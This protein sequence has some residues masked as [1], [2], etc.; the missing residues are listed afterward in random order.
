MTPQP[1]PPTFLW[2]LWT[3]EA[4]TP[5]FLLVNES[6][7]LI[8]DSSN[9]AIEATLSGSVVG[10]IQETSPGAGAV[11]V[12]GWGSQVVTIEVGQSAMRI[13]GFEFTLATMA[14]WRQVCSEF[15][16]FTTSYGRPTGSDMRQVLLKF[17]VDVGFGERREYGSSSSPASYLS[18]DTPTDE[19][20]DDP[21]FC[22][23]WVDWSSGDRSVPFDI[24]D[25]I[26][27][28]NEDPQGA[29]VPQGA[30]YSFGNLI[31]Y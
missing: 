7:Q 15:E 31:D 22:N 30:V 17:G 12:A 23:P 6:G 2:R 29:N 24:G 28:S 11:M 19:Y 20:P 13:D 1:T 16:V 10:S 14:G 18:I 5:K 25:G 27:C 9:H 26:V 4:A 8:L 21:Y 3:E